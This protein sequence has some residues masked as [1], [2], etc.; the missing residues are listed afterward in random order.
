MRPIYQALKGRNQ[1]EQPDYAPSG[2]GCW[3]TFRIHRA[4]P[5]AIDY[6]AF[7]P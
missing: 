6:R 4:L 5:C 3:E 1:I 2:L 7:S